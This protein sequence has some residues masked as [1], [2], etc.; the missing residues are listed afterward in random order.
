MAGRDQ[1]SVRDLDQLGRTAL[2]PFWAR[3]RDSV[4]DK[5]ILGDNAAAAIASL[6]AARFGVMQL[7]EQTLVG[8]CLRSR[9]TDEW[10]TELMDAG[11]RTIVDIG[12]GLDTRLRRLPRGGLR[13]IEVDQAPIIQL[14]DRLL[15]DPSVVR[16]AADGLRVDEWADAAE[17]GT[18]TSV[19][20]V[21]EG[22]LA[23]Q[24]PNHVSEFFT[25]A[26]ERLPGAFVLFDS[27]SPLG[28]WLANRPAA[29][30]RGRPRYTWS[31]WRTGGIRAGGQRL[32]I[33]RETGFTELPRSMAGRLSA[34]SRLAYAIPPMKRSYRITLAQL[35]DRPRPAS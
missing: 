12:V 16:I 35:P 21:L 2:V 29:S 23:Y 32:R 10:I 33:L 34:G 19:V 11:C 7:S 4:T 15:P 30:V 1:E 18:P 8:C 31:C 20:V 28:S 17:A 6:V 27:V 25:A 9:T 24:N 26:A 14:R 13:Y 3:V 22:V 5:P